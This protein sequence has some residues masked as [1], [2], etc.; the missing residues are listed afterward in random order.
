MDNAYVK[1]LMHYGI[2]GQRWGVRR[3]Q[4]S[5]G[6]RTPAG[7]AREKKAYDKGL[8]EGQEAAKNRKK[9]SSDSSKSSSYEKKTNN[10]FDKSTNKLK[11]TQTIINESSKLVNKAKQVERDTRP[12]AYKEKLDLSKMTDKELRDKINRAHLENEYNKLFAKD[13]VPEVSKGRRFAQGVL[14]AGGT[15]LAV[16]GSALGIALAIKEL[17]S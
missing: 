4:N 7:K 13:V 12:K 2:K 11:S 14:N 1:Y 9:T 3:Y 17:K 8:K 16:T 5:D 6:T 10:N 15:A